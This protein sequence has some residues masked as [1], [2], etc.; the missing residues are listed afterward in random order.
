MSSVTTTTG[1]APIVMPA[2]LL[3][4]VATIRLWLDCL[5]DRQRFAS[6]HQRARLDEAVIAASRDLRGALSALHTDLARQ[7][8]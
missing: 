3:Q 1:L 6:G 5:A 7:G 8:L 4:R 2:E